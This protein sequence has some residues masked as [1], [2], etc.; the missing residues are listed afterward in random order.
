MVLVGRVTAVGSGTPPKRS[1]FHPG[2]PFFRC[3]PGLGA[4]RPAHEMYRAPR[5]ERSTLFP[6]SSLSGACEKRS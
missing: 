6:V 2:S 4:G 5:I 3:Y 1:C